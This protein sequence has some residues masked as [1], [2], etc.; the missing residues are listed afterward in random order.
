MPSLFY[1]LTTDQQ[2][3]EVPLGNTFA[4][5]EPSA[6]WLIGGGLGDLRRFTEDLI[7][8][9]QIGSDRPT[10]LDARLGSGRIAAVS[11]DAAEEQVT[12]AQVLLKFSRER[13]KFN[14]GDLLEIIFGRYH[15]ANRF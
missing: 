10:Y 13:I 11:G 5:P 7:K 4:G 9:G 6:C 2:R 3:L 8:Q 1:R 14:R 15:A 12:I